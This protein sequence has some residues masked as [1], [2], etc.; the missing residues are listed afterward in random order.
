[1]REELVLMNDKITAITN[2]ESMI[3][4][5]WKTETG[6]LRGFARMKRLLKGK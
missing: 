5:M 1:M 3:D 4:D 2:R 6:R